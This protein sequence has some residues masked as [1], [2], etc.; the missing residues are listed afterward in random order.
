MAELIDPLAA[1]FRFDGAN[2]DAVILTHGFT[3]VP[4]HFRPLGAAL[5]EAGYTTIAPRLAGHGTSVDD[6]AMTTADDWI[7]SARAAVEA[8]ADHRRVHLVGLSMGGLIS[9]LLAEPAGAA[10]V[11]TINTPL[12]VRGKQ[13]YLAG[14][15][16]RFR[17]SVEWPDG[18]PPDLDDEMTPY[19]ITYPGFPTR[20]AAHLVS[21]MRRALFAAR[22]L[23]IPSLVIQS[24]TD[25]SVDPRSARLLA[26][27]L[28]EGCRTLWLE[29]SIHNALLDRERDRIA[30]AVL[31]HVGGGPGKR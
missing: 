21:I 15:L 12:I 24:K 4:A 29:R 20:S 10:T 1:G 30:R 31:E 8:V 22:R 9:L 28:G 16:H 7:D 26:R 17:P 18:D 27:L 3:G 11:T 2:G 5:N 6:L 14:L 13:L 23:D 25:E 19:W